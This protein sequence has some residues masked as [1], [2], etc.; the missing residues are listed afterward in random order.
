MTCVVE[1]RDFT[2]LSLMEM[3]TVVSGDGWEMGIRDR[4]CGNG[5]NVETVA[6]IRVGQG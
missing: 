6:G 1:N 2:F 5:D 4:C 3:G